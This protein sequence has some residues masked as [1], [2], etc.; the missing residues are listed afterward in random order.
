MLSLLQQCM[1]AYENSPISKVEKYL[2]SSSG[3]VGMIYS[4]YLS[5]DN[6]NGPHSSI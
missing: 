4:P 1:K 6:A 2:T 5:R 3:I